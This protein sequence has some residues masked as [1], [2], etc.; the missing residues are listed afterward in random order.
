M[1]LGLIFY[2][3]I[4][5]RD[6]KWICV[7][8]IDSWGIWCP[9]LDFQCISSILG[10]FKRICMDSTYS[11]GPGSEA[12]WQRVAGSGDRVWALLE[13]WSDLWL[14]DFVDFDASSV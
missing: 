10:D 12:V 5:S 2:D 14:D 9:W 11:W 7:D 3:F 13:V 4:D 1:V 6:F 8:F